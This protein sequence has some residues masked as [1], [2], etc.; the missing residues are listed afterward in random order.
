MAWS[1]FLIFLLYKQLFGVQ[2]KSEPST[3]KTNNIICKS[4]CSVITAVL[5][6]QLFRWKNL[7]D[8]E[9]NIH[10]KVVIYKRGICKFP[11]SQKVKKA[12][13]I[14][15]SF[16]QLIDVMT[17]LAVYKEMLKYQ[18]ILSVFLTHY[19]MSSVLQHLHTRTVLHY[20]RLFKF[21]VQKMQPF[22]IRKGSW[23][24]LLSICVYF[25]PHRSLRISAKYYQ[26]LL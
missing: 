10:A 14:G 5:V 23:F 7:K 2:K 25:I 19:W 26:H 11:F 4:L 1:I 20:K 15:Y 22:F 9:E 17:S 24:S 12:E 21:F 16:F 6:D 3:L 8:E 18:E 13:D